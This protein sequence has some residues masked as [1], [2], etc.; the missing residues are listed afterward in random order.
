[1]F[2]TMLFIIYDLEMREKCIYPLRLNGHLRLSLRLYASIFVYTRL[3]CVRTLIRPITRH[4]RLYAQT[5]AQ[6]R[7]QDSNLTFLLRNPDL[8][9]IFKPILY[10]ERLAGNIDLLV[11][12]QNCTI[13]HFLALYHTRL[14]HRAHSICVVEPLMHIF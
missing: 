13:P 3:S 11:R 9:G 8:V 14:I 5:C 4:P 10:R 12:Y 1:M 7:S 2:Y 6:N